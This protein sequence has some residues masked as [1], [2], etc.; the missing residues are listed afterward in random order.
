[1]WYENADA[2]GTFSDETVIFSFMDRPRSVV[3]A[4]WDGDGDMDV[5]TAARG[6]GEIAWHRNDGVG[7]FSTGLSISTDVP[8]TRSVITADLDGDDDLDVLTV[9]VVDYLIVWFENTDGNGTFASA[10]ALP[11]TSSVGNNVFA[12]DIDG[13]GD[14][15]ILSASP[16][17]ARVFWFENTDGLAD[18]T[19]RDDIEIGA[20][21]ATFVAGADLD[22]DET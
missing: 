20:D 16:D 5:L 13:D 18:F 8:D 15:D 7:G 3:A 9:T 19:L 11:T 22:G 21:G 12:A 10:Q 1:M 4:D 17:D 6:A 14:L 2:L